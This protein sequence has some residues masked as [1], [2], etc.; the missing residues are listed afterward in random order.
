MQSNH[1]F[2]SLLKVSSLIALKKR[3]LIAEVPFDLL[4]SVVTALSN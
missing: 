2:H 4:G 3:T 1:F